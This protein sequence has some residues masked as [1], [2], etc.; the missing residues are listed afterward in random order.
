M[1]LWRI[2]ISTQNLAC[3]QGQI[4]TDTV[5]TSR[6]SQAE[7]TQTICTNKVRTSPYPRHSPK[8]QLYIAVKCRIQR[9][10]EGERERDR[11]TERETETQ[12]YIA[13]KCRIQRER[14]GGRER[15]RERER[16]T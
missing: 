6:L 10:R 8:V 13:V 15:E 14:E 11:D 7:T 5:H 16:E 9:E 12:L 3:S 2:T 1:Y 4:H